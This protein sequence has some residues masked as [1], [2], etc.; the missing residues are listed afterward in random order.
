M[1]QNVKKDY[2]WNTIGVLLQNAASPI[3]LLI[4]T[5]V[6]GIE[7]AG[8]F[9]FAFSM[10]V[11]LYA[12]GVW[13]GRTFQVSDVKKEFQSSS[14]LMVRIILAVA[15]FV[16]TIVFCLLNQY[17]L[18]KTA[19][20]LALVVFKII[21][22]FSDVLYGVLQVYGKLYK[23]G[24]SL[25][26]K[27]IL[28][29]VGF[30]VTDMYTGNILLGIISIII[31][32]MAVFAIYDWPQARK[33]SGLKMVPKNTKIYI[34]EAKV[35]LKRCFGVFAVMFLVML[36]LNI[37]RYFIDLYSTKEVGYFGIMAMPITLIALLITFILQ[38]N[39]VNISKQYA[40]RDMS[41]FKSSVYK[42]LSLSAAIGFV[43]VLGTA[44]VGAYLLGLVFGVNFEGYEQAL[45]VIVVGGIASA[46][47]TVF[48]NIFVIMRKVNFALYALL[49]TNIVLIPISFFAV[50]SYGLSG[51][52]WAFTITNIV[53]LLIIVMYF[54]N[55]EK[56]SRKIDEKN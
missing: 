4:V 24:K 33:T 31:I 25:T 16:I 36:S 38:P 46:L 32:N 26:I 19:V 45:N 6:N 27:S 42:I 8:L 34:N 54:N 47:I 13:G 44:F 10:S 2:I 20:I 56:R 30:V 43:V 23:S 14:Y 55:I 3:L 28:G 22:S 5:R 12:I 7:A 48:L 51:G 52:V 35:I 21:E 50:Q 49:I 39:I 15:I 37:P 1:S 53:Q 40:A 11:L 18:Y 29:M 17:E 41:G 9:S